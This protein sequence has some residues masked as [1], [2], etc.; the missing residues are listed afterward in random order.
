MLDKGVYETY[1]S[2]KNN[3]IEVEIM[4]IVVLCIA[5]TI[6]AIG[7]IKNKIGL[8]TLTAYIIKKG[9]APPSDEET[10]ACTDYVVKNLLHDLGRHS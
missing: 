2:H 6:F 10:K 8:L 7:W 5:C 4:L 3:R 9:Y 1:N